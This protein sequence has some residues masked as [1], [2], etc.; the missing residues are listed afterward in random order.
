MR[1]CGPL[2]AR[3]A[4]PT[5]I[6]AA[7]GSDD[8]AEVGQRVA[9]SAS[10][11]LDMFGAPTG[12][13]AFSHV[14]VT[15]D[16]ERDD[17]AGTSGDDAST[18]R[19][20]IAAHE[21]DDD[22]SPVSRTTAAVDES[23]AGA[24][25]LW[26]QRLMDDQR[27]AHLEEQRDEL[28]RAEA[29]AAAMAARDRLD[30]IAAR[31]SRDTL[32]HD[33]PAAQQAEPAALV[34]TLSSPDT[35]PTSSSSGDDGNVSVSSASEDGD[36]AA[37]PCS[38]TPQQRARVESPVPPASPQEQPPSAPV[39]DDTA[40]P[41]MRGGP[42]AAPSGIQWRP[43][44]TAPA[45]RI[46]GSPL[47]AVAPPTPAPT[48]AAAAA[49]P[50]STTAVAV[51]TPSATP[52][53]VLNLSHRTTLRPY[54]SRSAPNS[55]ASSRVATARRAST[56]SGASNAAS[57]S[58]PPAAASERGT[59]ESAGHQTPY[60]P[61]AAA[62]ELNSSALSIAMALSKLQELA[63]PALSAQ[64]RLV[65]GIPVSA[66]VREVATSPLQPATAAPSEPV[67]EAT[68][69]PPPQRRPAPDQRPPLSPLSHSPPQHAPVEAHSSDRDAEAD[70][71]GS[72][73]GE[74]QFYPP[75]THH[76]HPRRTD[77]NRNLPRYMLPTS[78]WEHH[79]E[80]EPRHLHHGHHGHHGHHDAEHSSHDTSRDDDERLARHGDDHRDA[81]P[82]RGRS[83]SPPMSA[84]DALAVLG[85]GIVTTTTTDLA[86]ARAPAA[87]PA[88]APQPRG[89]SPRDRS[90]GAGSTRGSS[91]ATRKPPPQQHPRPSNFHVPVR[92]TRPKRAPLVLHKTGAA[93]AR[94]PMG[95]MSGREEASPSVAVEVDDGV[96]AFNRHV[97]AFERRQNRDAHIAAGHWDPT[98]AHRDLTAAVDR[99]N[100][101]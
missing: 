95:R 47:P 30:A 86:R 75:H 39:M 69:A 9:E 56:A 66:A 90:P 94:A 60:Q 1:P 81:D 51:V 34:H 80:D 87:A 46:S 12:G 41:F 31:V 26:L 6:A 17:D 2:G 43:V 100:E 98:V 4:P 45:V 48:T 29:H 13:G 35:S 97:A 37:T 73:D 3:Y 88:A 65:Q 52:V 83:A 78:S 8:D 27:A 49:K 16:A 54:S 89:R 91:P 99:I 11:R 76:H 28:L 58:S 42:R 68:A 72:D 77:A 5:Y 74:T 50:A 44:A 10:R 82:H 101:L 70:D 23:A 20:F 71:G 85:R 79:L 62:P 7:D 63:A 18:L 53:A 64:P 32:S 24:R 92:S 38:Q 14:V 96:A 22:L 84:S 15:G 67:C 93:V 36:R 57:P 59:A 21:D 40:S 25:P 61:P 55:A 33:A 19:A